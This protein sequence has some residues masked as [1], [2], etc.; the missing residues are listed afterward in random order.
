MLLEKLIRLCLQVS[1]TLWG[2]QAMDFDG[3]NEP[4]VAVK[5]AVTNEFMGA[6]SLSVRMSS[7][8]QV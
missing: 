2:S 1:L 4:V 7:T 8:L 5:G 3:R 6:K